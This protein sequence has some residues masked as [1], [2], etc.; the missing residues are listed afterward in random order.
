[1]EPA[2]KKDGWDIL[3]I[4]GIVIIAPLIAFVGTMYTNALKEQ[5]INVKNIEL[6]VDILK[7]ESDKTDKYVR[8]WAIDTINEYSKVKLTTKA[9]EALKESPIVSSISGIRFDL[10]IM[11]DFV[12]NENVLRL[13]GYNDNPEDIFIE[14][15]TIL[16]DKNSGCEKTLKIG[17]RFS[18]YSS[19]IAPLLSKKDLLSCLNADE[20]T[21]QGYEF[22]EVTLKPTLDM[23]YL[24]KAGG[25]MSSRNLPFAVNV[26]YRNG[27]SKAS[28][29][30]GVHLHFVQ[31]QH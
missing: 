22:A 24:I 20:L 8:Q 12:S 26:E 2:D 30:F 21:K 11:K 6:A 7:Q 29:L 1:M 17:T 31:I 16:G 28:S 3:K 13:I 15:V 14:S 19:S 18:S 27:S 10:N 5:E 9:Q 25:G 23:S 4:L